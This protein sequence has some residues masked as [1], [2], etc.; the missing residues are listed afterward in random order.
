MSFLC[1]GQYESRATLFYKDMST[2]QDHCAS[3]GLEYLRKIY[4][5]TKM[6]TIHWLLVPIAIRSDVKMF[7]KRSCESSTQLI[8]AQNLPI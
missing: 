5:N 7:H 4:C 1:F 8:F 2:E 3:T 6:S